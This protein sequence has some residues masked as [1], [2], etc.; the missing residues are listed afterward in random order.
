[1]SVRGWIRMPFSA[2]ASLFAVLVSGCQDE[3]APTQDISVSVV[4]ANASLLAGGS[5]DFTATV[6]NDPSARGVTWTISGCAGGAAACGSLTNVTSTTATYAAPATP[7]PGSLGVTATSVADNTKLFTASVAVIT[8]DAAGRIA[9]TSD[10]GGCPEIY[11]M[12]A[13][14][15]GVVELDS[16]FDSYCGAYANGAAWSPDGTK[17]AFYL[18]RVVWWEPQGIQVINTDGSTLTFIPD[19]RDPAWSPDGTRIAAA[20]IPRCGRGGCVNAGIMLMNTDGSG[21]VNLTRY[22]DFEPAWSANGRI[23][24][25]RSGCSGCTTGGEIYGMNADGTGL[26]N[27][28][29]NP[30]ADDGP[31]WSP[32][33]TKIA[34]RSDRTGHFDLYVMNADGSGVTALTA[35][36]ATEGR[37][38]WS[39][40]G[41]K[42]AFAS[43]RDGNWEIYV[44]NAD[45]S[46]VV[47][48]TN[49]A[50][51]DARP[52]W[53]R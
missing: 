7:P 36:T 17:L 48:L 21:L 11:A 20:G 9:F 35:D 28:T 46:G 19:L 37:P 32:H 14:G 23:A 5:Q 33:G 6:A 51:F 44:M 10:R 4:P 18:S 43:D 24:F 25:T 8:L 50:G 29:N 41:T 1:M 16:T 49:D 31:A 40:D 15:S 39:P 53:A 13:D 30:A 47:R 3:T 22:G 38:A 27:L 42:I 52:A 12:N 45:G 2:W 34:F 26:T